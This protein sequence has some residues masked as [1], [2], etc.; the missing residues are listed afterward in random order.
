MNFDVSRN[1]E[2]KALDVRIR[3]HD[4]EFRKFFLTPVDTTI[5]QEDVARYILHCI[6]II[7]KVRHD[8]YAQA[9]LRTEESRRLRGK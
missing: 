4:D 1:E 6:Q 5:P 8:M 2:H 7:D 9:Y 3:I